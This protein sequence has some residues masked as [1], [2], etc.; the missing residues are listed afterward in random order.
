LGSDSFTRFIEPHRQ[1]AV[2]FLFLTTNEHRK[3]K[4]DGWIIGWLDYCAAE[5]SRSS[6]NPFIQQS[7]NPFVPPA[8][9]VV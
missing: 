2:G 4:L 5:R 9:F 7:N 3:A 1:T 6:I 8:G